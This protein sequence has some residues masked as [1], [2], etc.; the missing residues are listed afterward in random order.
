MISV[1]VCD[2]AG[3]GV[4]CG[5]ARFDLDVCSVSEKGEEVGAGRSR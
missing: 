3:C 2:R 5:V 4:V 1:K